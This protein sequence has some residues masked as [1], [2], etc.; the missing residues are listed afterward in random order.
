MGDVA[1]K[2][3]ERKSENDSKVGEIEEME[4]TV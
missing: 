4:L 3:D 2:N 1:A